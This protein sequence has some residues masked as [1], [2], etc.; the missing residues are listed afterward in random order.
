MAEPA[1]NLRHMQKAFAKFGRSCVKRK[2]KGST[3]LETQIFF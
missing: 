3:W 2:R 1:P